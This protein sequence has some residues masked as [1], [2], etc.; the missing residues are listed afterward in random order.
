MTYLIELMHGSIAKGHLD[1]FVGSEQYEL[2]ISVF[3]IKK[4]DPCEI[5]FLFFKQ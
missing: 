1:I 3:T 2:E 5:G 4:T